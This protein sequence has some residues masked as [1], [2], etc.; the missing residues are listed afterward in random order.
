MPENREPLCWLRRD[1]GW[2]S[3]VKYLR[4]KLYRSLPLFS[5]FVQTCTVLMMT[6]VIAEIYLHDR[7]YHDE[8]HEV[9]QWA[10]THSFIIHDIVHDLEI[11]YCCL[12]S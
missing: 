3:F 12:W 9:A 2:G 7:F 8:N 4:D 10:L 1:F 6:V 5:I 11:K